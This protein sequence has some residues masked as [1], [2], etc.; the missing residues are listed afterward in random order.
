MT[1]K[2][3][4]K[5]TTKTNE[6]KKIRPKVK[7]TPLSQ[8][9]RVPCSLP[10]VDALPYAGK[11]GN[12]NWLNGLQSMSDWIWSGNLS[13]DRFPNNL[14]RF[15]LWIPGVFEQQL[16]YST[17]LIFDEPSFR[18]GIQI[19]GMLDR[20]S[21][22]LAINLI[23]HKR[24]C[25]YSMT[26]HAVL[27]KLTAKKHGLTDQQF[28]DKWVNVGEFD[29]RPESY[30]K[31]E[32]AILSFADSFCTNPKNYRDNQFDELRSALQ[33][34]NRRRYV[35]E[36]VWLE[37]LKAARSA[38]ARAL[39]EGLTQEDIERIARKAANDV[40]V[41]MPDELNERMING[42]VVELAFLCLQFVALTDV[43]TGLNIP[44]EDFLA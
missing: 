39:I 20:I 3:S 17:T 9:S 30:T 1:R 32:L 14:G 41:V 36:I 29:K 31:L 11:G 15:F 7:V 37:R 16:N 44:D 2:P 6:L 5:T 18:N 34:D 12:A 35:D 22:E 21:R 28:I 33:E 43:L 24:R 42:Q 4:K 27:G 23:A 40:S 10:L 25:W 26:H 8:E 38:R 13:E 19:S